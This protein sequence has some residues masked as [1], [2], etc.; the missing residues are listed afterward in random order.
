MLYCIC[1]PPL[2]III[3]LFTVQSMFVKVGMQRAAAS[4][5][6]PIEFV[7]NDN[8]NCYVHIPSVNQDETN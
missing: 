5:S 1:P 7:L 6:P 4:L 2:L 8:L 3:S